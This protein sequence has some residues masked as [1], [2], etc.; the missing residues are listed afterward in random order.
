VETD[1]D[2]DE[3]TSGLCKVVH[4]GLPQVQPGLMEPRILSTHSFMSKPLQPEFTKV[5]HSSK[6]I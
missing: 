2:D 6:N 1:D 5:L 3:A 4:L